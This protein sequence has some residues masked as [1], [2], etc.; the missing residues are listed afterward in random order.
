VLATLAA[1]FVIEIAY[2]SRTGRS[3]QRLAP[4]PVPA[5]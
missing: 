2:R 3:F 4:K 5:G 1:A